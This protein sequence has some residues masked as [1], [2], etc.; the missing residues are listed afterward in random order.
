MSKLKANF[1]FLVNC[2]FNMNMIFIKTSGFGLVSDYPVILITIIGVA[3][4][5]TVRVLTCTYNVLKVYI[6]KY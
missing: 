5:F 2:S 6:P 3:L 4:Y 1:N